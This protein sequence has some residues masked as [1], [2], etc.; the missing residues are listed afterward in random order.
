MTLQEI[1]SRFERVQR[2]GEQNQCLCSAHDD[3][4][5]SLSITE[6]DGKVLF[7]C[8]AGCSTADICAAVHSKIVI[9]NYQCSGEHES[10]SEQAVGAA[11]ACGGLGTTRRR[12]RRC[13]RSDS[14]RRG[15]I[16][17]ANRGQPPVSLRAK[18]VPGNMRRE[19]GGCPRMFKK[20]TPTFCSGVEQD[21]GVGGDPTETRTPDFG[22]RGRRPNR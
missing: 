9:L 8:H 5:A 17:S 18:A 1:L 20:T 13:T 19:T 3:R 4:N 16:R 14:G 22:V 6:R 12:C 7:Y 10:A 21:I 11:S 15:G 2:C